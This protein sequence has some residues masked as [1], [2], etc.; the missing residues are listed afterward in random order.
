MPSHE[1]QSNR[2]SIFSAF[3]LYIYIYICIYRYIY[4]YISMYINIYIYIYI[5]RNI[6]LYIYIYTYIHVYYDAR[7]ALV[8]DIYENMAS[9]GLTF[10]D[11]LLQGF[12][13]SIRETF[14]RL[15]RQVN[16]VFTIVSRLS[17]S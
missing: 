7:L 14:L 8:S 16:A 2:E 12:I 1:T 13:A 5:Y 10:G 9:F 15:R 3:L 17:V 4:I 11:S 6:Y